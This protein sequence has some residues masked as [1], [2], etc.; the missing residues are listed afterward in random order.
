MY[1]YIRE[2]IATVGLEFNAHMQNQPQPPPPKKKNNT[3]TFINYA[4]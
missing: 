2:Y 1:V 3:I 4:K